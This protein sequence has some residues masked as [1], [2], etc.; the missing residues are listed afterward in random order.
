MSLAE[1]VRVCG[2]DLYSSDRKASIPGPGHSRADRS[3]SLVIGRSGRVVA[4]SFGRSSVREILHDLKSQG[5]IDPA[6]YPVGASRHPDASPVLSDRRKRS[7]ALDLWSYGVPLA[8][9]LSERY[10]RQRYLQPNTFPTARLLHHPNCPYAVYEARSPAGPALMALIQDPAGR[11]SAVELT[12]LD[13]FGRRDSRR[14]VSR[15]TVGVVPPG[16]Y[17]ELSEVSNHIVVGEGVVTTLSA[18][19]IFKLP[20]RAFLGARNL[21]H[22]VLPEGVDE[23]TIAA[24]RGAAGEGA[25]RRLL[26]KLASPQ[27]EARVRLPDGASEDFN[28]MLEALAQGRGEGVEG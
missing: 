13:A 16:A 23:I 21:P 15:K 26:A 24:D 5:L 20:G 10:L 4:Y 8:G 25:A 27:V 12:Y 9:T 17:V 14:R 7:I 6:G 1:I 11:P 19:A 22:M 18:M 28:R 2:G 3:A